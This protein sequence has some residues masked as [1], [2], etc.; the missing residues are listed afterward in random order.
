M[1]NL[2]FYA[3]ILALLYY[4][5]I[6]L[7]AQKKPPSNRPDPKPTSTEST[8]TDFTEPEPPINCPGP[9]FT[10]DTTDLEKTLDQMIKGM[11]DLSK[12]LDKY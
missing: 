11:T 4:F 12:D 6:Y 2:L 8:Q 10:E 3:L 9:Q 1:D 5:L 7:P